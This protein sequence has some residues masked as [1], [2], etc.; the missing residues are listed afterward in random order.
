VVLDRPDHGQA[1]VRRQ[2]PREVGGQGHAV[3]AL[4]LSNLELQETIE[5][6]GA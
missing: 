6:G 1:V 3:F 2:E 4:P 5:H